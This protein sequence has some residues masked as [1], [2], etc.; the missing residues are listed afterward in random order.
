MFAV[1]ARAEFHPKSMYVDEYDK[2]TATLYLVPFEREEE[3]TFLL[4]CAHNNLEPRNIYVYN[5]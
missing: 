5:I 3:E 1:Q 4:Y 2:S